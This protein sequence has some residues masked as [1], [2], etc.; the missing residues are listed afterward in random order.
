MIELLLRHF[1]NL[2]KKMR[3]RNMV[4]H[5]SLRQRQILQAMVAE[6]L[7]QDKL[8]RKSH[9]LALP[10]LRLLSEQRPLLL[11]NTLIDP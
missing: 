11:D 5:M 9:L 10:L 3:R 2:F 4:I 6:R 1:G 8:L 7:D